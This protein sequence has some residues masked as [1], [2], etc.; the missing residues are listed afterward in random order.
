MNPMI[1]NINPMINVN[2]MMGINPMFGMNNMI[3]Q[4]NLMNLDAT[5]QNIK[6]II[7]PYENKIKQLEEIIRQKDFEIT[8]LKQKL[9]HNSNINIMNMNPMM[10]NQ[11]NPIIMNQMNNMMDYNQKIL[12]KG[13]EIALIIRTDNNEFDI[14]CFVNDKASILREKCNIIGG[15]FIFK[16]QPIDEDCTLKENRIEYNYSVIDIKQNIRFK[17][18]FFQTAERTSTCLALSYDCP[19][20]IAIKL[21]FHKK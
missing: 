1:N 15:I 19:L 9:N 13:K 8:V 3:N 21:F 20:G 14:K 10:A 4:T 2:P 17:N 18:I 16:Y 11:I 5:A 6:S 7:E 12:N